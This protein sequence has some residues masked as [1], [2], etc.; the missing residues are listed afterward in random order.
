M[1]R[2]FQKHGMVLIRE[3]QFGSDSDVL[4]TILLNTDSNI[5]IIRG[6][7]NS[8]FLLYTVYMKI[9]IS[10]LGYNKTLEYISPEDFLITNRGSSRW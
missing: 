8:P 1:W 5:K 2:F 6:G 10:N 3:T 7:F 9:F 4:G